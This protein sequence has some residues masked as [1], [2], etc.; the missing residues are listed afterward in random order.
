MLVALKNGTTE[1]VAEVQGKTVKVPITVE[2]A[3]REQ[4]INFTNEIVPIFSKL[5]CNSGACHG[6]ASGQ[7][8]F[9]L[10]LL[11]FEPD[12]DYTTLV[13]EGRGRRLF[14]A[15]DLDPLNYVAAIRN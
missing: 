13:K 11:G 12:L 2:G 10:S 1:V 8:G 3:E 5:G 15:A 7:N 14:P 4:P 6:K 9:K